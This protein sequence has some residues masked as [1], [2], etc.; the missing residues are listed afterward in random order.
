MPNQ[1]LI[2]RR[3]LSDSSVAEKV[4]E[5]LTAAFVYKQCVTRANVLQRSFETS[6]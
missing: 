5:L 6:G 2:V 4:T 3:T 1:H